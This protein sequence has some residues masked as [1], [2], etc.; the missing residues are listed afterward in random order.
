MTSLI[1]RF[2]VAAAIL[3]LASISARQLHRHLFGIAISALLVARARSGTSSF[4]I[5]WCSGAR[6]R[7]QRPLSPSRAPTTPRSN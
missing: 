6:M 1:R 7:P 3:A 5:S 4:R 2:L